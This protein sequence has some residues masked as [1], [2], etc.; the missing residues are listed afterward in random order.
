MEEAGTIIISDE[1]ELR[2]LRRDDH[3]KGYVS[4]LAQLTDV[5]DLTEACF[6]KV[7]DR[8]EQ[9]ADVYRTLVIE[10]LASRQT[11]ATGSLVVEAKFIHGGSLVGHVEDI[12]VDKEHRKKGLARELMN[13][14]AKEAQVLGCYKVILDCEADNVAFY[15]KCGW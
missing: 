4:L 15:E 5:G 13:A 10:H 9:Q 6:V 2:R 11:V 1:Y 3:R 7:F 8:R 14:L 12:V